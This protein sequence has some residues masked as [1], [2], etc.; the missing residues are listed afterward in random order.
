MNFLN[1]SKNIYFI[2]IGGIGM[3]GIAEILHEMGFKISGSDISENYNI[4][5]LK[6]LGI[7]INI[8]QFKKNISNIDLVV[9][10]SAIK[11]TNNELKE[12]LRQKI[13]VIP[14][15]KMLAEIMRLKSSITVSGSHGKTTTTSL[16][17]CLLEQAKL[18][19]TVINGGIINK[20]G[21]NAKLGKGD[22]II[23]EADES[24]GSFIFLPSNICLINNIDPEHLDYY[25][26]FEKL[27]QAF[28]RYA[29][30]VPFYGF[31]CLCIDHENVREIQSRLFDK[32]I[33][34]YGLSPKADFFPKNV[35]L[36]Q[37]K[38][39]YYTSFDVMINQKKKYELKNLLIPSLGIH[40]L[41]NVLG[42]ISVAINIGIK[43]SDIKKALLNFKGV[44]RRFTLV[45][46]N[47]NNKVFDDYAHHPIE[48]SATLSAMREITKGKII[49]IFEP[50]RY[51]R[52][53]ELF[54]DFVKCFKNS[55]VLFVLPV[56][57][58]GEKKIKSYTNKYLVNSILNNNNNKNIFCVDKP[59]PLFNN[60]K[61]VL[62][63]N[64]NV[65]FLGAGPITKLA[66]LFSDYLDK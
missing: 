12:S 49:V 30:N 5:R 19:P 20:Y 31:V 57:P 62:L 11:S 53:K 61:K 50:H 35:K 18:D 40:N 8:G 28:L 52:L 21:T 34:T 60:I 48:I 4:V 7:K 45:Y 41:K 2:G 17:A 54:S 46:S 64:D 25:K 37:R 42:A 6:K 55:D 65:I 38:K 23:A 47:N 26:S 39:N 1:K 43:K 15:A 66:Y 16:I 56:F 51:S 3:S 58:A 22:W 32:N 9:I 36:V 33:V 13:A 24:D 29:Q 14:R 59:L 63:P 10:S 44:K 27:K